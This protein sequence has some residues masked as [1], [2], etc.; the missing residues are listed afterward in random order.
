MNADRRGDMGVDGH[1]DRR[2]VTI[3]DR[4]RRGEGLGLGKV[5]RPGVNDPLTTI[6]RAR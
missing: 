2:S 1:R 6:V 3:V 4:G 5:A